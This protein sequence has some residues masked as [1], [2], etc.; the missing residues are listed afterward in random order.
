MQ[1]RRYHRIILYICMQLCMPVC[2]MARV[3]RPAVPVDGL[4]IIAA[5]IDQALRR[6]VAVRAERLERTQ[7]EAVP[8]PLMRLDVVDDRGRRGDAPSGT[9][10]AKRLKAQ[11]ITLSFLPAAIIV[12]A[13]PPGMTIRHNLSRHLYRH[14]SKS[15]KPFSARHIPASRHVAHDVPA[16]Q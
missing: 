13:F 2:G 3:R 6:F 15:K 5:K 8:V 16:A 12:P 11:L 7:P 9:H 10:P 4:G 1:H 14:S